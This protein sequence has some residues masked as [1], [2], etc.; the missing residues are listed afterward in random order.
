MARND[1]AKVKPVDETMGSG[2][3]GAVAQ[4]SARTV[5]AV[6]RDL[7]ALQRAHDELLRLGAN[8]VDVS[9]VRQG[10]AP[11]P[12]M[13]AGD[14]KAGAGTAAGAAAGVVLG[15]LAGLA[16][17]AIPGFGALIAAGPIV[18]ALGGAATGGALGA[19]AG[20]FAG[21][22][23]TNETAQEYEDAVR[24]GG[25]FL[26]VKTGDPEMA[27]RVSDLLRRY[28]AQNVSSFQPA[29]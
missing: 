12:P 20:S 3:A 27:E 26:S 11:A 5:V 1:P 16:A 29:L 6:F 24:S 14:T 4:I 21:L 2:I 22:G 10:D 23:M 25:T 19:L 13:S 28:G 7:D 18:A 9:I 15:G 17:V 8:E